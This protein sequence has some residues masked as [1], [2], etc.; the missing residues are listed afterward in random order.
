MT[1]VQVRQAGEGRGR[2]S[3]SST[4]NAGTSVSNSKVRNKGQGAAAL[5]LDLENRCSKLVK[6]QTERFHTF[7]NCGKY[8]KTL[9]TFQN[10]RK[11]WIENGVTTEMLALFKACTGTREACQVVQELMLNAISN[12]LSQPDLTEEGSTK[13]LATQVSGIYSAYI[14]YGLQPVTP[15]VC[16]YLP[17]Q[18][19]EEL[20]L[21]L[22]YCR[23]YLHLLDCH[24]IAK[25]LGKQNAFVYG[26]FKHEHAKR[27]IAFH[28]KNKIITGLTFNM[29]KEAK[30]AEDIAKSSLDPIRLDETLFRRYNESLRKVGADECCTSLVGILD[31]MNKDLQSDLSVMFTNMPHRVDWHQK[32][33][34][35]FGKRK[36]YDG[37]IM[38]TRDESSEDED[39]YL[40]GLP[41]NWRKKIKEVRRKQQE[42]E[43]LRR[44]AEQAVIKG[45]G[46]KGKGAQGRKGA[47]SSNKTKK[48]GSPRKKIQKQSSLNTLKQPKKKATGSV[49]ASTSSA[50]HKMPDEYRSGSAEDASNE[51]TAALMQHA[52]AKT[53][54]A[55]N[56]RRDPQGVNGEDDDY[57]ALGDDDV[58]EDNDLATLLEQELEEGE[59]PR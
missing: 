51:A 23:K 28:S 10:F 44:K 50:A 57:N 53:T 48:Q 41:A 1:P 45:K 21:L 9:F 29:W 49:G 43:E 25:E 13:Q 27:I 14:I 47:S 35:V 34:E 36:S 58:G 30:A 5:Q 37:T 3:P 17:Q 22:W 54:M 12:L 4:S 56:I 8:D 59:I 52:E 39:D 31:K 2:A 11:L 15:K 55:S 38:R 40:N 7:L 24:S 6:E 20:W 32:Y 33:E 46:K 19:V 16:I 26:A 18:Y 42:E